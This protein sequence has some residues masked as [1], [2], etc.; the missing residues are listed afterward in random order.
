MRKFWAAAALSS[1]LVL[2]TPTDAGDVA[3]Q[4]GKVAKPVGHVQVSQTRAPDG[5]EFTILFDNLAA[6]VGKAVGTSSIDTR[7]FSFTIPVD[8]TKNETTENPT[9]I[10]L[11]IRGHAVLDSQTRAV[12][13]VQAGGETQTFRWDATSKSGD[14]TKAGFP[15]WRLLRRDSPYGGS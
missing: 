8:A 1:L 3:A 15:R 6:E 7:E 2:S 9:P 12:L 11:D 5:G 10:S 14:F 4:F 13:L